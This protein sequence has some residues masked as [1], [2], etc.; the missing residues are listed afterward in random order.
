MKFK[1]LFSKLLHLLHYKKDTSMNLM[2]FKSEARIRSK[3]ELTENELEQFEFYKKEYSSLLKKQVLFSKNLDIESLT[4]DNDMHMELI[5]NLFTKDEVNPFV[6]IHSSIDIEKLLD[7]KIQ[8]EKVNMYLSDILNLRK[9]TEIRIMVLEEILN[10]PKFLSITKINA[11]VNKIENMITKLHIFEV[12]G[13][14]IYLDAL[15]LIKTLEISD[16]NDEEELKILLTNKKC[17]LHQS[18]KL[19]DKDKYSKIKKINFKTISLECAY[20]ERKLEIYV[21]NHKNEV[22]N[23]KKEI[24]NLKDKTGSWENLKNAFEKIEK[25]VKVFYLY[26]KNLISEDLINDLYKIKFTLF[27]SNIINH[28][29]TS[30]VENMNYIEME[31]YQNIILFK[32]ENIFKLKNYCFNDLTGEEYVKALKI[33]ENIMKNDNKEYDFYEILFNVKKL[34]FLLSFNN[35]GDTL[36]FFQEFYE[37]KSEYSNLDFCE[38]AFKWNDYLP[39]DTIYTVMETCELEVYPPLFK[40]YL[41]INKRIPKNRYYYKLPEGITKINVGDCNKSHSNQ[42]LVDDIRKKMK[43]KVVIMPSS[44]KDLGGYLFYGVDVRRIVLNE[45]LTTL[46]PFSID[47]VS[48]VNYPYTLKS[49]LDYSSRYVFKNMTTV[50]FE[51]YEY[52][53]LLNDKYELKNFLR[54]IFYIDMNDWYLE[55][56]I[57]GYC[58]KEKD[59]DL[60]AGFLGPRRRKVITN[61]KTI[62]F[63]LSHG[64]TIT[65]RCD[66]LRYYVYRFPR[67]RGILGE[68][69]VDNLDFEDEELEKLYEYFT[70]HLECR[71]VKILENNEKKLTK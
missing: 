28:Y 7:Y 12:Q 29:D 61:L 32:L 40:F 41:L 62:D 53:E 30:I 71:G 49:S 43:D 54:Q 38:D 50:V 22:E 39:L 6:S 31:C 48:E 65:I 67:F 5:S 33:L 4:N 60:E 69:E 14:A 24:E 19:L 26:G 23:I 8:V 21:Y 51:D 15:S 64:K 42:K 36:R 57:G 56:L 55:N 2:S 47:V 35:S 16:I 13:T 3:D 70:N 68:Y 45:G 58:L 44:L 11:I 10:S 9:E 27:T 17:F 18:L 52:S 59:R 20:L 1:D 37:P 25:K 46:A 66:E 34:A 63:S